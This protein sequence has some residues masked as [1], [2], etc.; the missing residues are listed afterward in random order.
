[1]D[2]TIAIATMLRP[3]F[4][5]SRVGDRGSHR[6]AGITDAGTSI[7]TRAPGMPEKWPER[8]LQAMKEPF[9]VT[10][11]AM[12]IDRIAST[13]LSLIG[14]ENLDRRHGDEPP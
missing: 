1:M 13:I 11:I 5:H 7:T 9:A 14:T 8:R 3:E 2:A 10:L 12:T 4:G 6:N